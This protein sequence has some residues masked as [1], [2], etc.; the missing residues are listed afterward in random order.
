MPSIGSIWMLVAALTISVTFL[1]NS[2]A[3][4]NALCNDLVRRPQDAGS[5]VALF[6]LGSQP[7]RGNSADR[8]RLLCRRDR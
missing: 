5:A 6:T 2:V 8:D 7:D 4:N 1:A 3:L